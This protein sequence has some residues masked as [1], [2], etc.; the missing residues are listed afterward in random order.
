M[1]ADPP[2]GRSVFLN[3]PFDDAFAPLLQAIAFCIA[4][5]DFHPRLAPENGDNSAARL[6]RIVELI[7]G[8]KFGIHDLSR[9]K[10]AAV[11]EYSRLNMPFE[12]GLD[13]ACALF[14]V[15]PLTAKSILIL[16][17]TRFD[18]QRSLSDIAGWDIH[19]HDADFVKIVRIVRDWLVHHA[20]AAPVG[21]AKIRGD[22]ATF[23]E[24]YWERERLRGASVDDIKAYPT[25]QVVAAMREWIELG[26]PA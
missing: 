20:G 9:C 4:D 19:A 14:G 5:L 23:Q 6:E 3:C 17:E 1:T 22:Y 8:C 24:W 7:R 11:G 18:Y 16:E 13:H 2:F 12:L 25:V 26:R 10:S 15:P 21:A